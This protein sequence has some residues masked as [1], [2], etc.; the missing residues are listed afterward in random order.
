[1]QQTLLL[2]AVFALGVASIAM[3]APIWLRHRA[4]HLIA[5]QG[6]LDIIRTTAKK[7][8]D[9][10]SV[11]EITVE[12]IKIMVSAANS[13]FL[14]RTFFKALVTGEF[15]RPPTDSVRRAAMSQ[16]F[17][18]MTAEQLRLFA[19]LYEHVLLSSASCDPVFAAAGRRFLI[20]GLRSIPQRDM[21]EPTKTKTDAPIMADIMAKHAPRRHIERELVAA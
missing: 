9:D 20:W 15:N 18:A 16:A 7:L 3:L 6:D 10:D 21:V 14:A 1:M 13:P 2:A 17:E 11:P 5:R 19:C 4:R 12:L 8:I